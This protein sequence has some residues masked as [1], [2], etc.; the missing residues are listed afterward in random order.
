MTVARR[1][2][3]G[4]DSSADSPAPLLARSAVPGIVWPGVPAPPGASLLAL[5]FQL[6]QSEWWDAGR[7]RAQQRTQL[8]AL[9]AHAVSEVPWYV[10]RDEYR[11]ALAEGLSEAA[12][13]SLPVISRPQAQAAGETLH[14]ASVPPG[15]GRL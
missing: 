9:L 13:A 15:H 11:E 4:R 6:A 8:R 5:Q 14:A 1:P 3:P 7:I 2:R 12:F 10:A